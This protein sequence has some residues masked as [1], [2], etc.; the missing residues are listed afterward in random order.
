VNNHYSLT[1]AFLGLFLVTSV[2][3]ASEHEV[4]SEGPIRGIGWTKCATFVEWYD[5]KI[6]MMALVSWVYGFWSGMNI[7]HSEFGQP[8]NLFS[9]PVS[10]DALLTRIAGR[11]I[12]QPNKFLLEIIQDIF[13]ELPDLTVE[14]D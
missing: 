6:D 10:P 7:F 5:A 9:E 12:E 4:S 2:S 11:C 1:V 14:Q 3:F 13:L 8:R